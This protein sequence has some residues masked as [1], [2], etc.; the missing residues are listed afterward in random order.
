MAQTNR[1][2]I[3]NDDLFQHNT[4]LSGKETY[5]RNGYVIDQAHYDEYLIKYRVAFANKYAAPMPT[6]EDAPRHK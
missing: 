1:Q 5:L 2:F 4:S 3:F 6:A